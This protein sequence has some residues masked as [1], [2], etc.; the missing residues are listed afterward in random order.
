MGAN[1]DDEVGAPGDR[2]SG[3]ADVGHEPRLTVD[4]L[5][6]RNDDDRGVRILVE[7]P[8]HGQEQLGRAPAIGGL[9]DAAHAG[10]IAQLGVV[11][12]AVVSSQN[13]VEPVG[14]DETGGPVEG[15]AEQNV[16]RGRR[17]AWPAKPTVVRAAALSMLSTTGENDAPEM[18]ACHGGDEGAGCS[19]CATREHGKLRRI[20]QIT[21]CSG[22]KDLQSL[23]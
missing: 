5:I 18:I 21:A 3:A 17:S 19:P 12:C 13:G 6:A 10:K 14:L 9:P 23:G 7:D 1:H 8:Q 15:L 20:S 11:V 4:E 22:L 16:P 2:L